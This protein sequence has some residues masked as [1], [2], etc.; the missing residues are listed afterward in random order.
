LIS[1]ISKI[2]S[3]NVL[4]TLISTFQERDEV[5]ALPVEILRAKAAVLYKSPESDERQ[6]ESEPK[7][8]V[9]LDQLSVIENIIDCQEKL[10]RL[11]SKT[12]R[13]KLQEEWSN[14]L[15]PNLVESLTRLVIICLNKLM[16][17]YVVFEHF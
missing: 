7:P 4:G 14:P 13:Q 9:L 1:K 11:K 15:G 2:I 5:M 8:L 16:F 6:V 3:T 12:D 17:L 10:N